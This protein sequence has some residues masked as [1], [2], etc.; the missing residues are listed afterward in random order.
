VHYLYPNSVTAQ[1]VA[2]MATLSR[3]VPYV[4]VPLQHA[5]P[6]VLARMRRGGSAESHLRLL[7]RFR[8]ALGDPAIR[9]TLI[10]GFPGETDA[11]FD[12]LVE[13]VRAARLAH[14]G[15]FTYSHE[16]GTPAAGL[17]D[18]VPREVKLARRERLIEVQRDV[19][20]ERHRALVGRETCVL[21]EGAHPETEHL[22]VGRMATQA[23]DV[24][25]HVLLND[26]TAAPGQ[27]VRVELTGIAGVELVGAI[28]GQA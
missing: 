27:F 19:V 24:D 22:L 13:F 12:L 21:V 28:R 14:L 6:A 1:L 16:A 7:E 8:R 23:P 3:V 17:D 18:D 15:V 11:E 5:H 10:V 2:A 26:G 25:G 20:L 4:D 9:S